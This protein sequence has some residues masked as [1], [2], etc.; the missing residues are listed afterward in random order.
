MERKVGVFDE[1]ILV[2]KLNHTLCQIIRLSSF[3]L[4]KLNL[5]DL[6]AALEFNRKNSA[7]N[8]SGE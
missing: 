6:C 2:N 1:Y 4:Q 3:W 8:S 5:A 7:S